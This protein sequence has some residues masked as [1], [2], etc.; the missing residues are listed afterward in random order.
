[1]AAHDYPWKRRAGWWLWIRR[2]VSFQLRELGGVVSA[3]Y[4]LMFLNMLQQ[5]RAG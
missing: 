4:G 1:M 2:Y 5:L 3:I